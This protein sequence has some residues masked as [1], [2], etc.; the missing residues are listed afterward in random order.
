MSQSQKS[1]TRTMPNPHAANLK[2]LKKQAPRQQQPGQATN[3]AL[4][5]GIAE[6]YA[7]AEPGTPPKWKVGQRKAASQPTS[8]ARR[9]ANPFR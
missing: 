3:I 7:P 2:P 8:F 4:P 1:P 9:G 5:T 6:T